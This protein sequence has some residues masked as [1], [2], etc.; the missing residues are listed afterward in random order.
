LSANKFC[1]PKSARN[2]E[3]KAWEIITYS[4]RNK[5]SLHKAFNAEFKRQPGT[6][7][8]N[9]LNGFKKGLETK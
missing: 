2:S 3:I 5:K 4:G 6:H 9:Q 1:A 8:L 7:F